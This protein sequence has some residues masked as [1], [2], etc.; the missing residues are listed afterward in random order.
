L[1]KKFYAKR[2][3][4]YFSNV[5]SY[6]KLHGSF[7]WHFCWRCGKVSIKD[8]DR[9]GV[10]TGR[11]PNSFLPYLLCDE[12]VCLQNPKAK[13]QVILAPC[14][15]PPSAIKAYT[16]PIVQELWSVFD[17][18]LRAVEKIVVIGCSMRDEDT[19]LRH[20]LFHL[21][22]KNSQLKDLVVVDP[23]E[24]IVTRFSDVI[25]IHARYFDSIENFAICH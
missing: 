10:F 12:E 23:N 1:E 11:H 17:E 7:N 4:R 3:H 15:I 18:F 2:E 24:E 21:S 25:G 5:I 20:S 9:Y 6:Y 16:S 8:F 19:L 13:G 14:V 22:R